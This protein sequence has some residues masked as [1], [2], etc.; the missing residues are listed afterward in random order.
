MSEANEVERD[1]MCWRCGWCGRPTRED[2]TPMAMSEIGLKKD[3]DKTWADAKLVNGECCAN[4][5][6]AQ[7][8]HEYEER[9]RQ[10]SDT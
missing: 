3:I 6:Q 4:D 2:C 9:M 10:Y 5:V 8:Q 7:D 1:V